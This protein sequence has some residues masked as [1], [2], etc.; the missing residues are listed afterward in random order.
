MMSS[1]NNIHFSPRSGGTATA[2][3]RRLCFFPVAI[4]NLELLLGGDFLADDIALRVT[5][6][7]A[8]GDALLVALVMADLETRTA[9]FQK[10]RSA[11]FGLALQDGRFALQFNAVDPETAS[12][13]GAGRMP[14]AEIEA[15]AACAYEHREAKLTS[16]RR[17]SKNRLRSALVALHHDP[18]LARRSG[19]PEAVVI[20]ADGEVTFHPNL[21]TGKDYGRA[22][23]QGFYLGV[24]D[25]HHSRFHDLD[26]AN[27]DPADLPDSPELNP[28]PAEELADNPPAAGVAPAQVPQ[29]AESTTPV[30]VEDASPDPALPAAPKGL[31]A[32][33]GAPRRSK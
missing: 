8:S 23:N 10:W 6:A 31:E 13:A 1:P 7:Q 28:V 27:L 3:P 21:R 19:V 5:A 2:S 12:A 11:Q 25:V 29:P 26:T 16:F 14:F 32:I 9:A 20:L 18:L 33:V 15:K 22:S 4:A 17:N 30:V 24:F